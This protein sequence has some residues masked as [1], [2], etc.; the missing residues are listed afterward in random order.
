MRRTFP[1]DSVQVASPCDASWEEMTGTDRVRFCGHCQRNVYYLSA[2]SRREA[3]ELIQQREGRLCIRFY[4][5][6]DGTILTEDCPVGLRAVRRRAALII[7]G[8]AA[9]LFAVVAWGFAFMGL[10]F[11]K[12]GFSRPPQVQTWPIAP[13]GGG[14]MV[15]GEMCPPEQPAVEDPQQIDP[16]P[17]AVPPPPVPKLAQ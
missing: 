7:G 16:V 12:G 17:A 2:M 13:P 10:V 8:A 9:V 6:A 11:W 14:G 5:R 15:A 1:L 4:R 3:E